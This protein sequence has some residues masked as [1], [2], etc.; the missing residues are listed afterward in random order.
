MISEL[1][2]SL[3]CLQAWSVLSSFHDYEMLRAG[4]VVENCQKEICPS[5]SNS[6]NT[7]P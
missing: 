3:A 1:L 2:V 6:K 5:L 4:Y 7:A